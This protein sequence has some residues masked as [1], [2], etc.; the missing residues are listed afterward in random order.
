[1]V[2][3]SSTCVWATAR[4]LFVQSDQLSVLFNFNLVSTLIF[5]LKLI[6]VTSFWFQLVT[7]VEHPFLFVLADQLSLHFNFN[8]IFL[9]LKDDDPYN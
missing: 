6:T 9:T 3:C 7:I 5:H 2:P 4:L 8:F 1:M